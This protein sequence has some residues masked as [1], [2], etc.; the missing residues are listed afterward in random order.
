MKVE[1]QFK[2]CSVMKTSVPKDFILN[3][4]MAI[5]RQDILKLQNSFILERNTD[6]FFPFNEKLMYFVGSFKKQ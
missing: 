3:G 6:F 2:V 5:I 1:N 4:W